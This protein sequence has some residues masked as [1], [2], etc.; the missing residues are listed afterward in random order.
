MSAC[1]IW[2]D[3]GIMRVEWS[4]PLSL[5]DLQGSF[6][7]VTRMV[8]SSAHPVDIVFDISA[9]DHIP[10]DAAMLAGGAKFLSNPK[11][12]NVAVVGLNHWAQIVASVASRSTGKSI[13]FYR[14]YE[15]AVHAM[16][17]C[18]ASLS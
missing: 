7:R 17:L 18:E 2:I 12:R 8:D 9:V 15:E 5:D 13:I 11:T 3:N 16:Y 10:V 14:S 4:M 1:E 6:V